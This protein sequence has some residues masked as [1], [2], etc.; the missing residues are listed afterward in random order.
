MLCSSKCCVP[1]GSL[2]SVFC[3]TGFIWWETEAFN[4]A[5][6]V[7]TY[8]A[9]VKNRYDKINNNKI[10]CFSCFPLH[11]SLWLPA[12]P[13][14]FLFFLTDD[15]ILFTLVTGVIWACQ[16]S[17]I[18]Q[19]GLDWI[20]LRPPPLSEKKN[21]TNAALKAPH[22]LLRGHWDK[23]FP[24]LLP[25]LSLSFTIVPSLLCR[26]IPSYLRVLSSFSRSLGCTPSPI[27][28]SASFLLTHPFPHPPNLSLSL[29]AVK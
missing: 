10:I 20:S 2:R 19:F 5:N 24:P 3:C 15:W 22:S 13:L 26:I 21:K 14:S 28:A 23:N 29:S 11:L 8:R 1:V 4:W 7:N 16:G 17:D 18:N 9:S 12:C 25:Y 27:S 6:F